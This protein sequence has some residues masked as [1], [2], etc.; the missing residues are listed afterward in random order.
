AAELSRLVVAVIQYV[1]NPCGIIG[2]GRGE[3]RSIGADCQV[4]EDICMARITRC[5]HLLFVGRLIERRDD[6]VIVLRTSK[7][8]EYT[9]IARADYGCKCAERR[10]H[11]NTFPRNRLASRVRPQMLRPEVKPA[12]S[13]RDRILVA[14][15]FVGL[16]TLR[17]QVAG[18]GDN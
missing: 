13:Q 12:K 3:V 16:P 5:V 18:S 17:Q 11:T 2:T 15:V 8:N 14:E 7:R 9:A 10:F 4:E 1:P 6:V